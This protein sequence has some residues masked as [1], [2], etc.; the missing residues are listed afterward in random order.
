MKILVVGGPRFFGVLLVREL[1]RKGHEVTI[2][3]RGNTKDD[4]GDSIHRIAV[5]RCD[6]DALKKAF[7]ENFLT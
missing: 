3:T 7:R 1:L 2:A 4:F 5:D 6:P